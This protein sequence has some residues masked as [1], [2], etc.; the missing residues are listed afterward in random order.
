[1]YLGEDS[2]I[3]SEF[4]GNYLKNKNRK[5]K[6]L[7]MG[8]GSGIQAETCL[9]L[10][11]RNI[12]ATDRGEDESNF[13]KNKLKS[14]K[15]IQSDLFSNIADKFDL[16]IFN[17]PYLPESKY[18]KNPDTTGGKKGD[19]TILMFLEQAK[20]YLT[21]NGEIIILLSSLTPRARINKLKWKKQKL[22]EKSLFFEK[23]E[24]WLLKL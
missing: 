23:L 12:T 16:I 15:V 5:I 11:F 14:I 20:N 9:K 24:I 4:L 1:M 19:E 10:G 2:F 7:D 13:L 3:L 6:I 18:D 8:S 21:D 22:E 17:P